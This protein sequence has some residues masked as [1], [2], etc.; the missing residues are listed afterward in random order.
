MDLERI[1]DLAKIDFF[2]K[3]GTAFITSVF[4]SLQHSWCNDIPTADVDGLNL[5]INPEFFMA[6]PRQIRVTLLAH[7]TWHVVLK[8]PTRHEGRDPK[9][10]NYACDF[11]INNQLDSE[12]YVIG[13]G[14]LV[15]HD[16]DGMN[17]YEIYNELM[18]IAE[19]LPPNPM[20]G[21][22]NPPSA[23][24]EEEVD[25]QID[26]MLIRGVITAKQR[27]QAGSVPGDI[28]AY[29]D[30]LLNP[31]LP[32]NYILR[33]FINEMAKD[34]Y[35]WKKLNK[36][37]FPDIM[38]PSLNSESLA[39]IIFYNDISCSVTDAQF[40]VYIS[41]MHAIQQ[42]LTP[43]KMS[44]VTFDTRIHDEYEVTP[45]M[46]IKSLTFTGRGGTSLDCVLAHAKK[47]KPTIMVVFSDLECAPMKEQ[48]ADFVIW[49]CLD[50]PSATVPFGQLIHIKS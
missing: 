14:W 10:W 49:V 4:C 34:D 26:N 37:F 36:R 20:A 21:D 28:Q 38:L 7:E 5:R 43:E 35:S 12:G 13:P 19:Q 30:E 39:H 50:N 31:K 40:N 8:H 11:F 9:I 25:A 33:D 47:H 16:Y 15:N 2:A 27:G 18:K 29:L 45:D 6:Q 22:I 46:D 44:I 41:E 1:Y 24:K 48:P 23:D 3:K 32:W 42:M 17:V